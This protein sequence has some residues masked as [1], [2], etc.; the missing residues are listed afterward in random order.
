MY[1]FQVAQSFSFTQN[2][3]LIVPL[4]DWGDG[5]PRPGGGDQHPLWGHRH[6]VE[7]NTEADKGRQVLHCRGPRGGNTPPCTGL[8][9]DCGCQMLIDVKKS[10]L[11]HFL[12]TLYLTHTCTDPS[13]N[14]FPRLRDPPLANRD[15]T[16]IGKAFLRELPYDTGLKRN[17]YSVPFKPAKHCTGNH[18]TAV[19][20]LWECCM[21]VEV[22]EVTN[23][24][25][26]IHQSW[27]W[28]YRDSLYETENFWFIRR[29]E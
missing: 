5:R 28:P 3:L 1:I 24:R 12:S 9:F 4:G 2:F 15:T 10:H 21:Q 16:Y 8:M 26:K 17:E 13:K 25:N 11:T 6:L 14:D 20:R 18:Y 7:G 23:G 22:E 27:E 19:P 29:V